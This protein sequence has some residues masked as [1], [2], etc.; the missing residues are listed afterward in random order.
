MHQAEVDSVRMERLFGRTPAARPE[1]PHFMWGF[2]GLLRDL[3]ASRKG[4]HERTPPHRYGRRKPR[5]PDFPPRRD[6]P[7]RGKNTT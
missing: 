2:F 4:R 1:K 5:V 3:Q 7:P 6:I